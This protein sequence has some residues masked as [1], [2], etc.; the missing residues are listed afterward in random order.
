MKEIS[1]QEYFVL[2][3]MVSGDEEAFKYFFDTHYDDLCNFVNSYL[4]DT[5]L[6]EDIVQNIFVHLWE[7]KNK[8][9]PDCSVKSYLYTASKNKSLN[10][11]RN[12]KNQNRI[13][14]SLKGS[15]ELAEFTSD[16]YLEFDELHAVLQKGIEKL[17]DRCRE[18]YKL[19]R[20]EGLSNKEIAEK[21]S[22]SVKT[23][24]NQVTIAIRKLKEH[25][26]PYED[27]IFILF[28]FSNFF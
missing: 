4:R 2:Q 14:E 1:S 28:L 20:N 9:P 21:L 7:N 26:Q 25:L 10:F 24:E 3:K 17:P 18:I 16:Q 8:L 11:L 22:I 5:I 6:S 27:Q 12:K 23:V 15:D 13:L 19:S